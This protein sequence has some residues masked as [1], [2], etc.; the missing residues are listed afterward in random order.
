MGE[1]E[2]V[3]DTF[4]VGAIAVV[5]LG[6]GVVVII[7]VVD[8]TL[9]VG[10]GEV[11]ATGLGEATGTDSGDGEILTEG[12][13]PGDK[14]AVGLGDKV[15]EGV[16][17]GVAVSTITGVDVSIVVEEDSGVSASLLGVVGAEELKTNDPTKVARMTPHRANNTPVFADGDI[18]S[19][20]VAELSSW[21]N[22]GSEGLA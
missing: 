11:V 14:V 5:E 21:I 1:G 15:G 16:V 19:E 4:V 17:I 13:V 20:I 7:V 22:S 9:L 10:L 6:E 2:T 12:T 8:A 18:S 3:G